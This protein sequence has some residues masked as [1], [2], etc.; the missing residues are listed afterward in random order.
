MGRPPKPVEL[1]RRTGRNS[2]TAANGSR[3]PE[4]VVVLAVSNKPPPVPT[5]L[6]DSGRSAWG[7]L[8]DHGRPWLLPS[9]SEVLTWLSE[10]YDERDAVRAQIAQDG[11]M[12][13][14]SKGQM[15]PHPLLAQLRAL[16]Q[17]MTRWLA[18]CGFDPSARAR[19][20]YA[21]VKRAS[22]LDDMMARRTNRGS[23]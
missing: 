1:K 10:A 21:E 12:V 23:A 2:T 19:L 22:A 11:Y 20:G 4:P 14:G 8:W 17:Q 9:D 15:R 6:G 3:L 18:A 7:R 16:E 13:E 5:T